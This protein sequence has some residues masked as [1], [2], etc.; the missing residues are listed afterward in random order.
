MSG[1]F[2]RMLVNIAVMSASVF[3]RA[4]VAA[5]HQALQ[6]AKQ[7]GGTAAK[8]ASRTYGGMAPDEAL[9]VLNLQKTDLKSSARI[10][11]QFDK[12]F[13]QNEPGKGGSFYLQSKVYRAKECLE[14]A[15]KAEKAKA[16][17]ARS[18]AEEARRENAQKRG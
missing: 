15:I 3:S 4:F 14:R 7:G 18:E 17:K 1:P 5:Y 11:E 13:S 2:V 9:K 8:A 16:G 12:Y 6:N 10:I